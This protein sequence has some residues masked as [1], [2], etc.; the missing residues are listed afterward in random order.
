[1]MD[2]LSPDVFK[3]RLKCSF[4]RG[5]LLWIHVLS[6]MNSI[7]QLDTSAALE[8]AVLRG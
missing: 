1:M 4:F 6:K 8:L 2:S 5:A 7:N 3:Q